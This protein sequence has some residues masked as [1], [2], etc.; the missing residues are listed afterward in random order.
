MSGPAGIVIAERYEIVNVIAQG[1]QALIC[2]AR[3][4]QSGQLVAVKLLTSAKAQDPEFVARLAREQEVML[5]L[6]GTN[7]V[8][9]LD[10]CRAQGGAPCLV[11]ELLEGEDLEQR[12]SVLE[13]RGELLAFDRVFEIFDPIVDTLERAHEAGILHRDLKPANIFLLSAESGGGVRLLDFGLSSM[14]TAAPLTAIGTIMG[15]PSYIAPET[16]SG[17]TARMD[18][19]ADVY[20]LAVIL[21]RV[22]SGHLPFE[23]ETLHDKFT[24]ATSA[25]RPSL[26][27]LRSDLPREL[28][29]WVQ[30]ALA[31]DPAQR[32]SAVRPLWN[33]LWTALHRKPRGRPRIPVAESIV[34]AWRA[35]AAKFRNVI[36]D[37]S[38]SM[39]APKKPPP[40]PAA[41]PPKPV[42]VSST[43]LLDS[44]VL[45]FA[46][47]SGPL[48][49][50]Q[51]L[52]EAPTPPQQAEEAPRAET[53]PETPR[54]ESRAAR[55]QAKRKR[56]R[57]R[58]GRKA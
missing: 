31:I 12:L 45:E 10:L 46:E 24:R 47:R 4:R 32:F 6:A 26:T 13:Q 39:Q 14:K 37:S 20:S 5:A 19:R 34:N 50:E 33:E 7:A 18:R 9:V 30:Q 27:A 16:W 29:A 56:R 3:D 42:E 1:G 48:D 51:I 40:R 28:D 58:K 11:M 53:A 44:D 2:R 57:R 35:A 21:F 52:Q 38:T 55:N 25:A 17:E 41:A 15:S 49:L 43:W 36:L 22:L 54:D 23:G 8:A